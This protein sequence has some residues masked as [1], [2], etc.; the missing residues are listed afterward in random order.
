MLLIRELFNQGSAQSKLW[1]PASSKGSFIQPSSGPAHLASSLRSSSLFPLGARGGEWTTLCHRIPN[2]SPPRPNPKPTPPN[3]FPRLGCYL[4]C[5]PVG[6]PFGLLIVYCWP[7]SGFLPAK[8]CQHILRDMGP[9]VTR[10]QGRYHVKGGL[11]MRL[12]VYPSL[13][14]MHV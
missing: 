9:P 11:A 10:M 3:A 2:S 8:G 14:L 7:M 12:L 5:G 13:E 6:R 1:L 4:G